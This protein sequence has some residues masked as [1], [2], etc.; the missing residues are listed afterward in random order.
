MKR[1]SLLLV[2]IGFPISHLGSAA[3]QPNILW[4]ITDDQRADS[5]A[6]FNKMLRGTPESP[7]G[8]VS[9]PNVDQLATEG[10]TFLHAYCQSAACAPSRSAMHT[11]RYPH[12]TGVYGFEM[13]HSNN[14]EFTRPNIPVVLSKAGYQTSVAGKLGYRNIGFDGTRFDY[15]QHQYEQYIAPFKVMAKAGY[16]DWSG[17]AVWEKGKDLGRLESFIFDDGERLDILTP[18]KGERDQSHQAIRKEAEERLDLFYHYLPDGTVENQIVGGV[19]SRS[20]GNTRDGYYLKALQDFLNHPN[21][22]YEASWGE[23]YRGP[24]T[25][26]PQFINLGFDFPHTPVLP[27]TS[28][29]KAF[30]EHAYKVPEFSDAERDA[31]PPQLKTLFHK[32][33]TS[34]F[35]PEEMQQMI[36]DYYAFCAYGDELVGEAVR[37]FKKYSKDLN[38][39]WMIL[40]VCGDHSVRLN[41]QGSWEKFGPWALDTHNP[42]IVISSDK[43]AFPAGKVVTDFVEFVDMAPTFY[44]AA[45]VEEE[46]EFLDGYDLAKVTSGELPARDYVLAEGWWVPGP[47]ATIRTKDYLFS[48]KIR[49]TTKHGKDMLWATTATLKEVEPLLYDLKKDP[50]ENNNIAH[51]A[52]YSDI[53]KALREKLQSIVLG[54]N[55]LEVDWANTVKG[56]GYRSHFA[57]GA[58]DKVLKLPSR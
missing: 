54:D 14:P 7:L 10:T 37:S 11:G 44:A 41:E 42:I 46:F 38:Q 43:K 36:R 13:H 49:N 45:G 23:R 52:N 8:Y 53:V 33:Q 20:A 55:R 30:A 18:K 50:N 32:K 2:C 35:T 47:R 56:K 5:I 1:I 40:Y 17:N 4:I 22:E 12:H 29:R 9:S 31:F 16:S 21:A 6:A 19:S 28:Y 51:D 15:S 34:H 58:D 57:P 3:P 48:I 25:S 27:P 24:D 39:P 26:R